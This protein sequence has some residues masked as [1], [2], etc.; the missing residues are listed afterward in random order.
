M[1]L[2]YGAVSCSFVSLISTEFT[3]ARSCQL[4]EF[5]PV[6][7][8]GIKERACASSSSLFVDINAKSGNISIVTFSITCF[9]LFVLWTGIITCHGLALATQRPT[10]ICKC[11]IEPL[12][13]GIEYGWR[14]CRG[15]VKWEA[16]E[17]CFRR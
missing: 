17:S 9:R 12:F 6:Y 1:V 3:P 10:Q 4:L 7:W 5:L 11:S 16:S 13:V 14:G 2:T 8:R 15:V